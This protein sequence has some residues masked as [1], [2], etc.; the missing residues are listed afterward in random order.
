MA[1]AYR[2]RVCGLKAGLWEVLR[3]DSDHV[4]NYDKVR[5][6]LAGNIEEK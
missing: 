6:A 4:Q 5:E 1:P 3:E 2:S